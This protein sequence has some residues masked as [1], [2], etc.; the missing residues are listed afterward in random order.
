M[1]VHKAVLS[2]KRCE[3]LY[4]AANYSFVEADILPEDSEHARHQVFDIVQEGNVDRVTRVLNLAHK[5]CV[6]LLFPYTKQKI[7]D[8][9]HTYDDVL[10]EIEEYRI[11][12]SLPDGF[13]KT[14]LALLEDLVH[15]YLVCR[16][17]EDW[18]SITL[19]NSWERWSMK[20]EALQARIRRVL[21]SRHGKVKRR[22]KP[23]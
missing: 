21:M 14:T 18:L 15:E 9:V 19:P 4:D 22:L 13:S 17:L 23:W 8:S 11:E 7:D 20:V 2:F 16:V 5:E 3:L 10:K 6:E 1:Q 12:L